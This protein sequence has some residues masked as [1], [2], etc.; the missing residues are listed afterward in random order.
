MQTGMDFTAHK[1][2][3]GSVTGICVNLFLENCLFLQQKKVYFQV[4][5]EEKTEPSS[6]Y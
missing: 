4:F 3:V 5:V 2:D 1:H 6:F